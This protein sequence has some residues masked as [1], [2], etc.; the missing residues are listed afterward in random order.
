MEL[1]GGLWCRCK[2]VAAGFTD[3]VCACVCLWAGQRPAITGRCS[4]S[5]CCCC[6]CCGA[7]GTGAFDVRW[8]S[9][10]LPIE[11]QRAPIYCQPPSQQASRHI[12]RSAADTSDVYRCMYSRTADRLI[13][14]RPR[15]EIFTLLIYAVRI[16][17]ANDK[18]NIKF[19]TDQGFSN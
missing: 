7:N 4:S 15:R 10:L 17:K 14:P 13:P 2:W 3:Q 12:A 9:S 18:N 16:Q 1:A 8:P 5:S 11:V 19:I 6:S